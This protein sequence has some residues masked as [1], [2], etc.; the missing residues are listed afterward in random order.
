MKVEGNLQVLAISFS[1]LSNHR[2]ISEGLSQ[3]VV[4][5][6]NCPGSSVQVSGEGG[7]ARQAPSLVPELPGPLMGGSR[8]FYIGKSLL[9]RSR[10]DT[11]AIGRS[12][13]GDSAQKNAQIKIALL[14]DKLNKR[15]SDLRQAVNN[16]ACDNSKRKGEILDVNAERLSQ[17]Q[18][19]K[20]KLGDPM[21]KQLGLDGLINQYES[22]SVGIT[23]RSSRTP[24]TS[25]PAV[26]PK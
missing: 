24:G 20:D 5:V 21:S 12:K 11:K 4:S 22:F 18:A 16:A 19:L 23:N 15:K 8:Y 2:F 6:T 7:S 3:R 9:H 14:E 17:A 13:P 1:P 26:T 25:T 10:F